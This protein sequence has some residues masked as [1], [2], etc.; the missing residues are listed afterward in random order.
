MELIQNWTPENTAEY[1]KS[2]MIIEHRLAESGLFTDEALAKLLD[3]HPNNLIDFQH[4]P[5]NPDYPD[6]QVTVDFS[7]A[8]GAAMIKA[9]R[10]TG[11]V[12]INVREAMNSHPEYKVLLD[13]LHDEMEAFTGKNTDRRNCRGGILISSATAATPY[14][15]DPTITH[16]WH[17]RGHKKAWVY[18]RT[19]KCMA[20]NAYEAI[21]LGEVDEDMPFEYALDKE[22]IVAPAN[23][24]GGEMVCWPHRSPHRV[25]NATYCISMVMEFSTKES[26]FTNAGM[27]ANGY[28]RRRF[29]AKPRAWVDTPVVAKV[30]KAAMGRALMFGGVRKKF[31]RKDLVRYKFDADVAG[32]VSA[33]TT[34][35]E[36]VH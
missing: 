22:A 3:K 27:F 23:L 25:E 30:F 32:F 26:A 5:D 28:M 14:H 7:G 33:V 15:A 10:S 19:Q 12:W 13:Q 31:R 8:D 20:D 17:I 4:I 35:Y 2:V 16:L 36:R 18:P 24:H 34:P 6:Q 11:R 29:N 9:A 21:V 1:G